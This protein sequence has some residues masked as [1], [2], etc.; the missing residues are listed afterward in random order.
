METLPKEP[1]FGF[2]SQTFVEKAAKHLLG[3]EVED[4]PKANRDGCP[5][6]IIIPAR[7]VVQHQTL[8]LL[9]RDG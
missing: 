4:K 1:N 8:G 5:F 6:R 3:P 9:G 2:S 7:D